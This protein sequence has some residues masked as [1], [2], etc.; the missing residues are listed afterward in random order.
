MYIK[1]NTDFFR[2]IDGLE[3]GAWATCRAREYPSDMTM[4]Q[5]NLVT[6]L[7][8]VCLLFKYNFF[9]NLLF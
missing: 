1:K 9:I 3:V 2:F 6:R 8:H 7:G 4:G 5:K